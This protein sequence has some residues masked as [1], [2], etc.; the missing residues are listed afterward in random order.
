MN[1]NY[2]FSDRIRRTT[3]LV[4]LRTA[5]TTCRWTRGSAATSRPR[6]T[7][8]RRSTGLP[9][10][11]FDRG[12]RMATISNSR[13]ETNSVSLSDCQWNSFRHNMTFGGD[14][15]R[16]E[17][18]Y[19]LA[20]EPE[21][22]ARLYRAGDA[23]AARPA[24]AATTLPTSCWACRTPVDCVRQCGQVSAP[25]GV[26]PVRGRRLPREPGAEHPRGRALGVSARR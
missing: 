18:N 6:R 1:V 4:T 12:C 5:T 17:W 15:R 13:P 21:G 25:V 2:N 3:T 8:D 22:I 11:R 26:R 14:F 19:L 20:V 9:P 16:Q 24:R 10:A 7:T 23:A